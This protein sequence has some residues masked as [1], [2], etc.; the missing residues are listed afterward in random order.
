MDTSKVC[1]VIPAYQAANHIGDVIAGIPDF[2]SWIVVVND[3]STDNTAEVV[4]AIPESRLRLINLERNT[5]VGGATMRGYHAACQLGASIVVKMDS[6]GQM[7]PHYLPDLI[8][9]VVQGEADYAKGN[10]FMHLR[11]LQ[12][13]PPLRRIGNMGLSLLNKISSG[14]WNIFD[15]TN[16]YTAITA[17]MLAKIDVSNLHPR[18]FFEQSLL[19]E[20][21]L[22]RAVVKDVYIPARYQNEKSSLSELDSLFRFPPLLVR[23]FFRRLFIQYFV[24]DFS[25]VT[26]FLLMGV[27]LVLFGFI[28]GS[29]RWIQSIQSNIPATTGTVMVAVLPFILGVQ[30]IMQALIMDIQNVPRK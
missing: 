17:G 23:G 24:R 7:D 4:A 3:A 2:V 21:G 19:L 9:P 10:R 27:P 11:K 30:F 25:A 13:M 15:P 22:H 28:F 1:V 18:Y 8:A 14:Y 29:I 12:A 16:G 26:L 6:D 5:G 20:L